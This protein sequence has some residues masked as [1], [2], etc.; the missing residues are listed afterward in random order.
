MINHLTILNLKISLEQGLDDEVMT[1]G[2]VSKANG[3]LHILNIGKIL[4]TLYDIWLWR[5]SVV[6]YR[7]GY[8]GT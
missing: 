6:V 3:R 8:G 4:L 2:G 5:Y 7:G 1:Y